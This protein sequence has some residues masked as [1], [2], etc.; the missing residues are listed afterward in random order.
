[1]AEKENIKNNLINQLNQLK[2]N[3]I[4]NN[5]KQNIAD[6]NPNYKKDKTH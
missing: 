6:E 5:L 4:E 3:N 2:G 1:M